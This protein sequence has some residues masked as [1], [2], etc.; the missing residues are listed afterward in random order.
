[1]PYYLELR[2]AVDVNTALLQHYDALL[3]HFH[4]LNLRIKDQLSEHQLILVVPHDD[5]RVG[6]LGVFAAADQGHFAL[7]VAQL[8]HS[9]PAMQLSRQNQLKW[10]ALVNLEANLCAYSNAALVLV[11]AEE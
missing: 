11:E 1:M 10:I 7:R 8:D 6:P 3:A 9:Y 2:V 5:F 4:A